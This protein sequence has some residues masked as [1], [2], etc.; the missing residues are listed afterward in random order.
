M[1][2]QLDHRIA[3]ELATSTS[4]RKQTSEIASANATE[5]S[6]PPP[7]LTLNIPSSTDT[8]AVDIPPTPNTPTSAAP[9]IPLHTKLDSSSRPTT[10][11]EALLRPLFVYAFLNPGVSY[12]QGMSYL[13]AVFNYVFSS[14]STLS[15]E[16]VEATTFFALASLVSQL[17]DLYVP[18]HD[19]NIR[20]QSLSHGLGAT[21]ER[22][23]GL[24]LWLD[25]TLADAL[26]RK[27]VELGGVIL[28][29][30]TTVFA[31]EVSQRLLHV[32]LFYPIAKSP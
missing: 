15:I 10:R 21:I 18:T 6:L 4:N 31:N 13:A 29:W 9:G 14:D 23:N 1:L 12:V 25:P 24:L 27:R 22:F 30:L 5:P 2:D 19:T 17:Q 7:T 11:R 3:R 20:G 8:T 28:R 26:D 32:L 16:E